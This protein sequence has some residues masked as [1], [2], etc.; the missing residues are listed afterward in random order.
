MGAGIRKLS[1]ILCFLLLNA[2]ILLGADTAVRPGD[3]TDLKSEETSQIALTW[4]APGADWYSG[5]NVTGGVWHIKGT[6][7]PAKN[8]DTAEY[9]LNISTNW[10]Y[11]TK[12]TAIATGL[13]LGVTYYFWIKAED[14]FGTLASNWSNKST[15]TPTQFSVVVDTNT[16][17]SKAFEG[18]VSWGDYDNDNDLDVAVCGYDGVSQPITKIY[19]N[20]GGG[21]FIDIGSSISGAGTYDSKG[22][23]SWGDY[24]NDGD[25]D[26]LI[27]GNNGSSPVTKIY[28][29]N[30]GS[31]ADSGESITGFEKCAV[32]WGDY[33]NDGYLDFAVNGNNGFVD[34]LAV[35]SNDGDGTFTNN[36]VGSGMS[37]SSLSWGDYDNDGDLDIVTSG[38]NGTT[39]ATKILRN[40]GSNTFTDITAGLTGVDYGSTIW[41]DYDNDGDLDLL[42]TGSLG[43]FASYSSKIYRNDG[44]DTF[45]D[46]SASLTD[47]GK[48]AAAWG[49]YD[50][51]GD[52]DAFIAGWNDADFFTFNLYK[53][54][55]SDTFAKVSSN[56][57]GIERP[58]ISLAD[59][60]NDGD[61]DVL[62][63]GQ[64][65]NGAVV[66]IY[67][68]HQADYNSAN[69]APTAPSTGFSALYSTT[70]IRA[71][72]RWDR[73]S[74]AETTNNK[75]L[76][77][78]VRVATKTI[79]SNP[80]SW[81]ISPSKGAGVGIGQVQTFGNYPHGFV[82]SAYQPG[83]DFTTNIEG[84][85]YYW[86]VRTLDTA[87]AKSAWADGP[88]FYVA[89]KNPSVPVLNSPIDAFTT[90]YATVT[91]DWQDTSDDLYGIA[92]YELQVT[93]DIT[94]NT[95]DYSSAPV[96]SQ[97]VIS[98]M[99]ENKTYYWRVRAKNNGN[100]FSDWSGARS[101]ILDTT[102]PDV[103][104]SLSPS[105]GAVTKQ[106]SITFDWGNV[107]DGLSGLDYYELQVST[108]NGFDVLYTSSAATASQ[109]IKTLAE[110]PYYWR[111]RSFDN[112]GNYSGWTSILS[113]IV[114]TSNPALPVL[115]L[116][117]D[118]FTTSQALISFDWND[119]D[120]SI[121]G[122]KYYELQVSAVSNFSSIAFSSN[123]VSSEA[124]NTFSEGTYYWRVLTR[125]NADNTSAYTASRSF[126]I[127]TSAPSAPSLLTPADNAESN[128]TLVN[129]DWGDVTDDSGIDYYELELSTQ[130]NF[131][132]IYFSS[133]PTTSQ[134]YD[135][136]VENIYYWRVRAV[137]GVSAQGSWSTTRSFTIDTSSPSAPSLLTPVDNTSQSDASVTFDWSDVTGD[138]SG[139]SNYVIEVSTDIG[140][141]A[142]YYTASPSASQQQRN[143][144][145]DSYYWR[146]KA[147]DDVGYQSVWSSVWRINI[148]APASA[149]TGF[150]GQALSTSIIKWTWVDTANNE[151]GYRVKTST[152]GLVA[153]LAADTTYYTETGLSNNTS[154]T[155]YVEAYNGVGSSQSSNVTKYTLT[156]PPTALTV[157]G[158]TAY[159]ADLSW[160]GSGG[161]Q[162]KVEYSTNGVNY[163]LAADNRTQTTYTVTSLTPDTTYTF[164]VRGYNGDHIITVSSTTV[165]DYTNKIPPTAPTGF[166]GTAQSVSSI[167]WSWTDNANNEDGYR[168]KTSTGGILGTVSANVT[169]FNESG[170]S[171]NT[172]YTRYAE[173][174][175][176]AGA[177]QSS[178]R[179][180]YTLANSPTGV[181]VS[182][183]GITNVTLTWTG[184]GGT[185]FKVERSLD[186]VSWTQVIDNLIPTVYNVTGL[187]PGTT[188]Q[189]SVRGYNGDS[190]LTTSSTT[191]QEVTDPYKVPIM[192]TD[193]A[194]TA[195]SPA[196][197]R[198]TWKDNSNNEDKFYLRDGAN[199]IIATITA[200]TELYNETGLS[201]NT[202][203]TRCIEAYHN[204]EGGSKTAT[205]SLYTLTN[206][207]T[208][209]A[210]SAKTLH[211]VNLTWNGNGCS[212][213]KLDR[214]EDAG[215]SWE[216]C[217]TNI[218]GQSL[219]VSELLPE[220]TYT[221]RVWGYN[222]DDVISL[223]TASVNV[224]TPDLNFQTIDRNADNVLIIQIVVNGKLITT[225]LLIP[226]GAVDEIAYIK[227]TG[228]PIN[229]PIEID[230]KKITDADNNIAQ[231]SN[232]YLTGRIIEYTMY[233]MRGIRKTNFLK[234][235]Q[236]VIPYD[237]IN[238]DGFL[239]GSAP[240]I[241]ETSLKMY[242]LDEV[243]SRWTALPSSIDELSN[244]I[245]ADV[246][247][248]SV[249]TQI[250]GIPFKDDLSNV[251]VY[252]NPYKPGS[253]TKFD[254]RSEGG[255]VFSNLTK[256]A[257]IRIYTLMGEPV[258]IGYEDNEDGEY[259]WPAVNDAGN[260]A[261]SGVYVYIITN[262]E[263]TS[264]KAKGRLA[265]IR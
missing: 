120:S 135:T 82:T 212:Y 232:I 153:S 254:R 202:Q 31:F 257:K 167:R 26:L 45:T 168:V 19:R 193:F 238:N 213:Y 239:D 94:F 227:P 48:S 36:V 125:D 147:V 139:I 51:D 136:L 143:L 21:S 192:P 14:S 231:D 37:N 17:T 243:S 123:P 219:V 96:I 241:R 54:N 209:L 8:P 100:Y 237:D 235:I 169:I 61:L 188:Y 152:N 20:N 56:F 195:L 86:Q 159:T 129:F 131:A 256:S 206:N 104:S 191:V 166:D 190:I 57:N 194:G 88:V 65:E 107:I 46:I 110:N 137:N 242:V 245:T 223:S 11:N 253:G 16:F 259:E 142:I 92:N 90:N 144:G 145:N 93:D 172:A 140:F 234:T 196:S 180:R 128:Q 155:R 66:K 124:Y 58:G 50:N 101:F 121:A 117:I 181:S 210:V 81:I 32:A 261:A 13:T 47:V 97:A 60:D 203:Y 84:A 63:T 23:L 244:L 59:F 218:A 106:T 173:G 189:F 6:A 43:S 198:W 246:T 262:T 230:S 177:T 15:A 103:P 98:S 214:T 113:L 67:E 201:P 127:D 157:V 226:K 111:V 161:T 9:T 151:D 211:T 216:T 154:Y 115:S 53:N 200:N 255:I 22:S 141:G 252:P 62:V 163:N 138:I 229:S 240:P 108:Y 102:A 233:S 265:I 28:K 119:S 183:K 91:F 174:Y 1:L 38:I 215:A 76:Y 158:K 109:S 2:S 170:L 3:I 208:A 29:N 258:F 49:D 205:V 207:P 162:F 95:I 87:G 132:S 83:V 236:I 70:T 10:V 264:D 71:E 99:A 247:H 55:G 220:T 85:T 34:L 222:G 133:N 156:N 89:D 148:V 146:V 33:N 263:D 225:K 165:I 41:G 78:D 114:D 224:V 199:V 250:G 149:P 5:D 52:L 40:D 75:G 182:A 130:S 175:N 150:N 68:N 39:R 116:P 221:F 35:Y 248:F 260:P 178:T 228:D 217:Q 69:T 185:K 197:I 122:L 72:L 64:E 204:I 25:L 80:S 179:T 7:D 77:Y 79:A 4:T 12:Q 42:V 30:N 187:Q 249:F 73:A 171:A 18:A 44:S 27:A 112:A 126:T 186:G 184:N 164:S 24:D 251:V 134:A 160:T 118:S 105:N 176:N 74:D